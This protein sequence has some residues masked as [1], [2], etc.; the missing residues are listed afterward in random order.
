MKRVVRGSAHI[1]TCRSLSARRGS[2]SRRRGVSMTGGI[3]GMTRRYQRHDDAASGGTARLPSYK[4]GRDPRFMGWR[5][6]AL[7]FEAATMT[8][9]KGDLG[10]GADGK[11]RHRVLLLEDEQ[12]GRARW[13][14]R[15][16]Q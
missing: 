5:T 11:H 3:E 6:L 7:L 14:E 2:R 13:R 12:I 10:G 15:V 8:G 1:A 9:E 4:M 16:W